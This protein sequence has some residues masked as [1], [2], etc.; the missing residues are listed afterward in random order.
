MIARTLT[1]R[2]IYRTIRRNLF[3]VPIVLSIFLFSSCSTR[4]PI[5]P[6]I[7]QDS[8]GNRLVGKFVWYDLFIHDLESIVP[9]YEALFGWSFEN[10]TPR[11]NLVKT[12]Y[13]NGAPIGNGVQVKP[14]KKNHRESHWL[15]FLSVEDVDSTSRAVVE[16]K[17][18][19]HMDPKDLPERGRVAVIKDP[20][21][22]YVALVTSTH[23]DPPDSDDIENRWVGSELWTRS[24]DAALEFYSPLFDY[25]VERIPMNDGSIYTILVGDEETRAAVVK[26][27][28]EEEI[29][30]IWIPYVAVKDVPATIN[31]AEN[32]GGTILTHVDPSTQ[33]NPNAIIAD[34]QG[35]VF[36]VVQISEEHP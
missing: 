20:Q 30:P 31:K 2:L 5:V 7:T 15:G 11:D 29:R 34:P 26:I 21:G 8:T 9:F 35:T 23:G 3:I 10:I 22:A 16:N 24:I 17:G 32:L 12:I 6:S 14:A 27:P 13:R 19:I 25:E 1:K 36:G 28:W 4:P 18:T 33:K